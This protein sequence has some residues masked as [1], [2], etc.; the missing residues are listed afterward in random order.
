MCTR[1]FLIL[2]LIKYPQSRKIRNLEKQE[3]KIIQKSTTQKKKIVTILETM[4]SEFSMNKL[5]LKKDDIG[6]HT[7]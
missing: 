3:K 5:V 2:F 6:V 1:Q 4:Y 7:I